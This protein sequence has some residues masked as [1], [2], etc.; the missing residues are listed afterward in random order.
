[1]DAG[2]LAELSDDAAEEAPALRAWVIDVAREPA[3]RVHRPGD[4]HDRGRQGEPEPRRA[5][6]GEPTPDAAIAERVRGAPREDRE[7]EHQAF[8][9]RPDEDPEGTREEPPARAAAAAGQVAP[10]LEREQEPAR[11]D[12]VGLGGH[13]VGREPA[14][15]QPDEDRDGRGGRPQRGPHARGARGTIAASRNA[16]IGTRFRTSVI[17]SDTR[18]AHTCSSGSKSG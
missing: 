6:V 1:M 16:W 8:V 11:D 15:R 2:R 17:R 14:G 10:R 12:H 3:G 13:P 18:N 5:Q 4:G 7:R 9:F